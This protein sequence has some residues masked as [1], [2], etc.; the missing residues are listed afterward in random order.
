MKKANTTPE[1][2]PVIIPADFIP[3]DEQIDALARRF[4]PEI[5]RFFADDEIQREFAEWKE[6]QATDK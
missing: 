1:L 6:Q 5:K 3:S 2:H 4:M